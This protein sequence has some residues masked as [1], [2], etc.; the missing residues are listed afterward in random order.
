MRVSIVDALS[1][2]QGSTSCTATFLFKEK[3]IL[4][5]QTHMIFYFEIQIIPPKSHTSGIEVKKV[6][7]FFMK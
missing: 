2:Q 6:R 1:G 5:I 4:E 7:D 3:P